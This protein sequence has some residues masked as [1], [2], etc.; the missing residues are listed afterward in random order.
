MITETVFKYFTMCGPFELFDGLRSFASDLNESEVCHLKTT[1][2][3]YVHCFTGNFIS[4][5]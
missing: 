5:Q 2:T 1:V 3:C 4:L